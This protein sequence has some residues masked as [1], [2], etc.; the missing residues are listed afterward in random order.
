[1]PEEVVLQST[2]RTED[3]GEYKRRL[4]FE[5]NRVID[6]KTSRKTMLRILQNHYEGS[7]LAYDSW[8][9][10]YKIYIIWLSRFISKLYSL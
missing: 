2:T 6:G 8:I 9:I 7:Q 1:M 3:I 4:L 10:A 5:I